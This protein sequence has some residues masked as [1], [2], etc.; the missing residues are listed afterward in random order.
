MNDLK[1]II[2]RLEG[3]HYTEHRNVH[4]WVSEAK[5]EGGHWIVKI[6]PLREEVE[7]NGSN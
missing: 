5:H 6:V 2:L 3:N 7:E 1:E 4:Y